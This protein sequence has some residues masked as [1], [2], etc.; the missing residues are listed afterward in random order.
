MQLDGVL[1]MEGEGEPAEITH[2]K[3]DLRTV[4]ADAA[5]IGE[6]LSSAMEAS[7]AMAG[8]LVELDGLAGVLGERHRIIA[9]DWQAASLS[10]LAGK[11]VARAVD[12]LDRVDFTPAAL[13]T[14]LAG[15]RISARR[16]VQR[17]GDAQPRGRPVQ[18]FR[19]ARQRQRTPLAGLPGPRSRGAPGARA[20][21]R[22][23]VADGTSERHASVIEPVPSS[24]CPR[25]HLP[26]RGVL[27]GLAAAVSFGI[28]AP[29]A[30]RL[31]DNVPAEMLAGLLYVG[32]F[33]ALSIVRRRPTKEARLRRA[34]APRMALMILAGGIVAP[35]LLLVGLE[36]VT[37][38]AGS[39]L[40]NLEGPFTIVIGVAIFREHLHARHSSARS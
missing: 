1:F 8:S 11:I 15:E 33:A 28:S 20:R 4:A 34:D 30:K 2:L 3:R 26:R 12:L 31:L 40:L 9:N 14:D 23:D 22:R 13:R 24:T 18:R 39:L 10:S 16:S 21:G 5:E 17:G 25:C 7:W 29:L 38:I 35:V 27:F 32:A 36:R 37:G 19:R 6:W